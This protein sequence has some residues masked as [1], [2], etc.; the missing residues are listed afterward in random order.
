MGRLEYVIE[1]RRRDGV[2]TWF[3]VRP[4]RGLARRYAAA[5]VDL[6]PGCRVVVDARS[7]RPLGVL[8]GLTPPPPP[9]AGYNPYFD[10]PPG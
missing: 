8:A 7:L 2:E 10:P 9:A 4:H 1:T 6:A 3:V 5:G